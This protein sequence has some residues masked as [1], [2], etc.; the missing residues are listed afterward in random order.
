MNPATV[1]SIVNVLPLPVWALWILAPRA[2]VSRLLAA[3]LWPWQVLAA[4]YLLVLCVALGSGGN[5]GPLDFGSLAG[6]MALFDS[7]WGTLAGWVHYLCFDLFVARWIM[8]DAPE[9]GYRL[10]P[11]LFL[12]LMLGPVGL[13]LYSAARGFFRGAA[14]SA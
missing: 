1:F 12:T 6:V 5:T 14:S 7:E 10:A 3:S 11:V 8:N 2:R 9:G 4:L 13:L